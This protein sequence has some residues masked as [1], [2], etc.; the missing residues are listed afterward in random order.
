M[1]RLY[2][3]LEE[4]NFDHDFNNVKQVATGNGLVHGFAGLHDVRREFKKTSQSAREVLGGDVYGLFDQPE[5]WTL[6]T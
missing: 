5:P 3:F 6:W 4:P 2:E 1:Q